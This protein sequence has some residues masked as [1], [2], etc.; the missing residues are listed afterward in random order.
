MT[1]VM[2]GTTARRRVTVVATNTRHRLLLAM[3]AATAT[4]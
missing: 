4:R 3:A 1:G 2:A